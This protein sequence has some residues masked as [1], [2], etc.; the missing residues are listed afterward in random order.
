MAQLPSGD[1]LIQQIGEEVV[2]FHRF[3]EEEIV[4]YPVNDPD[5]TAQAQ[6]LIAADPDL[7]S[8]DRSFAHFWCGYF[9]AHATGVSG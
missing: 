6:A 5:L 4:R 9:W 3:T 2:L 1:Y 7:T 8:E